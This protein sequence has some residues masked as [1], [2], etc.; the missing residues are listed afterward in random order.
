MPFV[1]LAALLE[2]YA[3]LFTDN[4]I[5]IHAPWFSLALL[6]V[7]VSLTAMVRSY[8]WR[9]AILTF[10]LVAILSVDAGFILRSELITYNFI[11][12]VLDVVP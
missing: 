6:A 7:I 3:L 11:L 10:V 12:L 4:G 8:A 9:V 1:L 5:L 2:M